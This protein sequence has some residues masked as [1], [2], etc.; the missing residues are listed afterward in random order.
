MLLINCSNREEN[1]Y[2]ILNDIKSDNDKLLSLSGKKMDFCL[3][4]NKCQNN[5]NN[6]CVL[7]DYITENVYKE[8]IA[9]DNIV[10]A[11]PMY[12]SNINAILKN[13]LDRF[14]PFYIHKTL[15]NKTFY[16]IMTGQGSKEINEEEIDNVINYFEGISEWVSFKF[17]FLD[18]F[19][20]NSDSYN[21]QIE[22]INNKL[23]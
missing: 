14:L 21:T 10:L 8:I 5:L 16:L 7:D 6:Y 19:E 12:M 15:T 17:A 11:S 9:E 23:R 3:G 2:K 1:C 13:L 4:C 18:Y 22:S 20:D